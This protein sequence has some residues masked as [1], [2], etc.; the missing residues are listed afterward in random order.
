MND[1]RRQIT[2]SV[3]RMNEGCV[4]MVMVRCTATV[5]RRSRS[6]SVTLRYVML[7]TLTLQCYCI[8]YPIA[9]LRCCPRQHTLRA[10]FYLTTFYLYST[11]CRM[12][13]NITSKIQSISF[14]TKFYFLF[15][16]DLVI[17]ANIF[18]SSI[19]YLWNIHFNHLNSN[20]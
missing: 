15:R 2:A 8:G 19:Y 10:H 12:V 13:Y 6:S 5:V 18:Y 20:R 9:I 4:L 7:R 16:P 11:F 17:S 1:R 3:L 14:K